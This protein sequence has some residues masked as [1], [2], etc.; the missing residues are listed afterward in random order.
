MSAL[1]QTPGGAMLLDCFASF[2]LDGCV[3]LK[4]AFLVAALPRSRILSRS[5]ILKIGMR[6]ILVGH[7]TQVVLQPHI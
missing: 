4:W 7:K 2:Q 6:T 1:V 5:A 3:S